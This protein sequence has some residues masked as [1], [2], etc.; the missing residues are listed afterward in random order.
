MS[1]VELQNVTKIFDKTV[2]VGN[3]A[4]VGQVDPKNP[5][6][7]PQGLELWAPNGGDEVLKIPAD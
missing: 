5:Y 2:K 7:N 3:V 6:R 1:T 4:Q